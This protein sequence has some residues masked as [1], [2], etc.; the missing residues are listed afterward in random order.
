[1]TLTYTRNF[2]VWGVVGRS[3]Y[4]LIYCRSIVNK[5]L[6]QFLIDSKEEEKPVH[7]S[8]M[9]N[10]MFEQSSLIESKSTRSER[11]SDEIC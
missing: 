10:V 5:V 11:Q 4:M 9:S 3:F 1:M 7:T 2:S 6:L 8:G